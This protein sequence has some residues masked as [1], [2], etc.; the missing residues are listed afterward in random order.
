MDQKFINIED[1]YEMDGN[2]IFAEYIVKIEITNSAL[3]IPRQLRA[4]V[5]GV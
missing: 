1:L 4:K 5:T 3:P 2:N